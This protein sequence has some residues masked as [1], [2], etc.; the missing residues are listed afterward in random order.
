M[1]RFLLAIL[2]CL[3][4]A[5]LA[6]AQQPELSNRRVVVVPVATD[7]LW[8]DSFDIIPT[9]LQLEKISD[10][11]L[12]DTAFYRVEGPAVIWRKPL[13]PPADSVRL[14]YRVFPFALR[15]PLQRRDSARI[16]KLQDSNYIG[17][18]YDPYEEQDKALVEFKGL[19]YNGSFA[20]GLSFGNSQNLVLN[21]S[22]NLQLAG[23]L[24]EDVEILA[25]ISDNSIPLQPEG[26]TA[27][28]NEFDRIFIQLK[29][30]ESS[31]IAGDFELRRPAGYFMNYFKNLQGATVQ[32][33]ATLWEKGTLKT[34]FSGAVAKGKFV[35]NNL[36]VQE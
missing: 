15:T 28:L 18:D 25:A 21:S 16:K 20:R 24:G 13:N 6:T 1:N 34:Q 14:S 27:Q 3:L 31:L 33:E 26:N 32:N 36:N 5:S 29:R 19:D 22:F 30:K 12:I 2:F 8:R 11:Q 35:R 10:E 23:K 4:F 7:T 17:Y 9:S